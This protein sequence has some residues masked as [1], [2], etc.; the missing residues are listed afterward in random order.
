MRLI[1]LKSKNT[2]RVRARRKEVIRDAKRAK[3]LS[4]ENLIENGIAFILSGMAIAKN[5][6]KYI[7]IVG[8]KSN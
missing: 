5:R 4:Q 2:N 6:D 1:I 3:S 8:R 7:D